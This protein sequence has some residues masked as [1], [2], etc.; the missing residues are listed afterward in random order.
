MMFSTEDYWRQ[1]A[2]LHKKFRTLVERIDNMSY[3][4]KWLLHR[5]SPD[6]KDPM[7]PEDYKPVYGEVVLAGRNLIVWNGEKWLDMSELQGRLA[8]L[9]L[10]IAKLEQRRSL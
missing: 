4:P 9:E 1:S 5:S 2:A 3:N 8:E 6:T 10:R 7:P